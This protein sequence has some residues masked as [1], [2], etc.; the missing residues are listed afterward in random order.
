MYWSRGLG[1]CAF[2]RATCFVPQMCG[3]PDLILSHQDSAL[4][5]H[6][7]REALKAHLLGEDEATKCSGVSARGTFLQDFAGLHPSSAVLLKADLP[8]VERSVAEQQRRRLHNALQASVLF[9]STC[10]GVLA[11]MRQGWLGHDT[12][13]HCVMLRG[14]EGAT[15]SIVPHTSAELRRR[16]LLERRLIVS[17]LSTCL[18]LPL[19]CAGEQERAQ[20][21]ERGESALRPL[22]GSRV[23]LI[24]REGPT[25]VTESQSSAQ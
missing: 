6:K 2:V 8:R 16:A 9:L 25:Q 15:A 5:Y 22:D 10:A 7:D 4:H 11:S 23:E 1:A 3:Q 14:H 12:R 21:G 18:F 17:Y 19:S 24:P 20:K 13:L